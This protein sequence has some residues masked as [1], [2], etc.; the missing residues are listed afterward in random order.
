M[1]KTLTDALLH[2]ASTLPPGPFIQ[3]RYNVLIDLDEDGSVV[4]VTVTIFPEWEQMPILLGRGNSVTYIRPFADTYD[5]VFGD[6]LAPAQPPKK[7]KKKKGADPRTDGQKR[8]ENFRKVMNYSHPAAQAVAAWF[9]NHREETMSRLDD[10]TAAAIKEAKA[11][12]KKSKASKPV[13]AFKL[14]GKNILFR[15]NREL[16]HLACEPA[17]TAYISTPPSDALVSDC[18]VTGDNGPTMRTVPGFSFGGATGRFSSVNF[19]SGESQG[20]EQ[21][22][23][24][25]IGYRV[26]LDLVKAFADLVSWGQ[27]TIVLDEGTEDKPPTTRTVRGMRYGFL[28]DNVAQVTWTGNGGDPFSD[29][30][31]AETVTQKM[32]DAIFG[33]KNVPSSSTPLYLMQL[34]SNQARVAVVS[35]ESTRIDEATRHLRRWFQLMPGVGIRFLERILLLTE[36]EAR[37]KNRATVPVASLPGLF[38]QLQKAFLFGTPLSRDVLS[39]ALHAARHGAYKHLARKFCGV[40]L[41]WNGLDADDKAATLGRFYGLAATIQVQDGQKDGGVFSVLDSPEAFVEQT[42]RITR[43]RVKRVGKSAEPV[44]AD[45]SDIATKLSTSTSRLGLE[46]QAAFWSSFFLTFQP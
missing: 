25:P 9:D 27:R 16:V 36:S 28:F 24:A 8:T 23:V 21:G 37:G 1:H 40:W 14:S 19:A 42:L 20:R 11:Q 2:H 46:Q 18:L 17:V 34:K 45:M 33:G 30:W 22:A 5:V 35:F 4:D 3:D 32:C 13:P 7:K 29:L 31:I 10:E 38:C 6:L 41:T 26:C 15:V 44:F 43:S 39:L 12:A